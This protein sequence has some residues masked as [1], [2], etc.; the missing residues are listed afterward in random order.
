[1]RNLTKSFVSF[2]WA[3]SM[4]G[5]EQITNMVSEE[6]SGNRKERLSNAFDAVTG[7]TTEIFGERT[8]SLYDSGNRLQA[9]MVD[10]CF[11]CF[12]AENWKPAKQTDQAASPSEVVA[13][14]A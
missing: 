2:S 1:M 3:M 12:R 10:L 13:E 4:F 9:E 5:L 7:A 11:D 8:R 6:R 14:A